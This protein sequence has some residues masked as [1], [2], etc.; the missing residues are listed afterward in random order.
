MTDSRLLN[1]LN[2]LGRR[3]YPTSAHFEVTHRCNCSCEYCYLSGC[4]K[5]D[6]PMQDVCAIISTL[7]NNG[8]FSLNFSGGE[9][10]I[11]PDI[12]PILRHAVSCDFFDIG[13]ISNGT[14][15]TNEHVTF[16]ADNPLHI[17]SIQ[18]SVFSDSPEENDAY[19]GLDGATK[20]TLTTAQKLKEAGLNVTFALPVQPFNVHRI[21]AIM[22][23]YEHCGFSISISVHK[24][25]TAKNADVVK[26]HSSYDFFKTMFSSIGSNR[27]DR[28][29]RALDNKLKESKRTNLCSGIH[30]MM[31]IDPQGTV[32]PCPSFRNY[33]IGNIIEQPDLHSLFTSDKMKVLHQLT[34]ADYPECAACPYANFCS[35]CIGKWHTQF[36]R[37]GIKDTQF[38]NYVRALVDVSNE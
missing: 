36:H 11:R 35:I 23:Y 38:C 1:K 20:K 26:D 10:F 7:N 28:Y 19:M 6:L 4:Q 5:P 3:G 21:G 29:K 24:I 33:P 8:I 13:I 31:S 17:K 25:I 32:F 18:L 9:L 22:D 30:C 14:L 15:I 16:L 34:L 12:I 37:F 27:L 2:T